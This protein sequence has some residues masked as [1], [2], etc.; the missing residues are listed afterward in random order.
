MKRIRP[1]GFELLYTEHALPLVPGDPILT[2]F[3]GITFAMR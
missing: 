2:I 3:P 1:L